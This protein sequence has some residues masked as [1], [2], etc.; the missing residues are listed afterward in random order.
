MIKQRAILEKRTQ[1]VSVTRVPLLICITKVCVY[2]KKWI[3]ILV[4]ILINLACRRSEFD[5]H[6]RQIEV[7]K[8]EVRAPLLNG[9]QQV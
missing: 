7:V 6:S 2:N 5:P 4:L 9:Q 1:C 8:Q 3:I